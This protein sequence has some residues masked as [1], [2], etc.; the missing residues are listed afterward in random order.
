MYKAGQIVTVDRKV[1]R[2]MLTRGFNACEHCEFPIKP[3]TP[4]K[5][6][7][8]CIKTYP[9]CFPKLIEN[10]EHKTKVQK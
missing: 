5:M 8:M 10:V 4:T 2:F 7:D 3:C 9:D 1:Y 6:Y